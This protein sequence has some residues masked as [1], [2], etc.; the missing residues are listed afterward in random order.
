V[1]DESSFF[2]LPP[3]TEDLSQKFKDTFGLP[4][5]QWWRN[6]KDRGGDMKK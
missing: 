2:D 6:R 3:G 4:S 5:P 1:R